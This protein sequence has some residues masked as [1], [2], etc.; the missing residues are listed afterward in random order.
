MCLS[1]RSFTASLASALAVVACAPD[2][3]VAG[4]TADG[5]PPE[6]GFALPSDPTPVDSLTKSDAEWKAALGAQAYDVLRQKGTERAF[7]GRYWNE[8]RTGTFVCAGCNLRLFR[9]ED[10]FESGTGWPSFTRPF[11]ADRV[12][13]DR[14]VSYGM[15]RDEVVCA[16]CRGHLGHVFD[17]GPAPTGQRY[18]MNSV[19]LVFRPAA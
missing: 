16:R 15:I 4:P 9:S 10:K 5:P 12:K 7:S 19:S 11:A 18:C 3:A 1:R 14:D 17:D 2:G 8:H 13:V 6:P